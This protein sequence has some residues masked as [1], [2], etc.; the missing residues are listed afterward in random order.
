MCY[1][2]LSGE[3]ER[4]LGTSSRH[5]DVGDAIPPLPWQEPG[6][7]RC[8]GRWLRAPAVGVTPTFRG[9]M[10]LQKTFPKTLLGEKRQFLGLEEER[11]KACRV[12]LPVS[13]G[14]IQRYGGTLGQD[15]FA[16]TRLEAGRG[17]LPAGLAL[18]AGD[19]EPCG[20]R[21]EMLQLLQQGKMRAGWAASPFPPPAPSP[22]CQHT[23]TLGC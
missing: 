9:T 14:P 16:S 20:K 2:S 6:R 1:V 12:V 15:G 3:Q 23:L 17:Q 8:P 13:R 11:G 19:G 5:G 18:G 4:T 7:R 10:S 22:A 21:R